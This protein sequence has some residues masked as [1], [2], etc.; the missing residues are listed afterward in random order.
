M[1]INNLDVRDSDLRDCKLMG[2]LV[3]YIKCEFAIRE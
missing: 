3:E 1:R 2:A